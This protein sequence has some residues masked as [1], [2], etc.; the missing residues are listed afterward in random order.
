MQNKKIYIW[1]AMLVFVLVVGLV[2]WQVVKSPVAPSQSTAGP[3]GQ[4]AS[5]V[6]GTASPAT[7]KIT[8]TSPIAG[9]QWILGKQNTIQWSRTAGA[10]DGTITLINASTSAVVGWIQQHIAPQQAIFPWNTGNVLVSQTSG[11]TENVPPGSYRIVLT[12]NSPSIPSVTGPVFSIIPQAEAQIPATT[13]TIQGAVFSSSSIAIAQGTKLIFVN[14]DTKSYGITISSRAP[15]FTIG[16]STSL[17]F[18]TSILSPGDYVF[19]STAYPLL[20]LTVI[21]K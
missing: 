5:P 21:T 18:D 3:Q 4:S 12:F 15:S 13:V 20:R 9:S 10:L 14:R 11:Q 8:I 16:T 2:I 6:P 1:V 7:E 17:I 19:Y